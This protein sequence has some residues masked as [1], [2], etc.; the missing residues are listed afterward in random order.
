MWKRRS[1]A[2]G[3]LLLS[4]AEAAGLLG[5]QS[6]SFGA[7]GRT[8]TVTTHSEGTALT[9]DRHWLFQP[10]V[11]TPSAV[12]NNQYIMLFNSNLN[13]GHGGEQ[14][15]AVWM[16][17]SA[18]GLSFA[19]PQQVLT[20]TTVDN[21]CDMVDARPIWGG[22]RWH[23]YFQ[24]MVGDYHQFGT[25]PQAG[26]VA[27]AVTPLDDTDLHHL[28]WVLDAGTN[29]AKIVAST[30]N[31]STAGIGEDMQPF[32]IGPYGGPVCEPAMLTFNDYGNAGHEG[33]LRTYLSRD[34]TVT[35][36]WFQAGSAFRLPDG[37]VTL[38]D[39]ILADALD[40]GTNGNPGLGFESKCVV[41]ASL[42][43]V[44]GVGFYP[45][46]VPWPPRAEPTS[47]GQ[48]Q[49][50]PIESTRSDGTGPVTFRPKPARNE[51]GYLRAVPGSFPRRWETLL[52]Y[53]DGDI[54][55]TPSNCQGEQ[56]Y[57][58]WNNPGQR[59]SVSRLTITEQ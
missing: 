48:W 20:N 27:E 29:H 36:F 14:G 31:P 45:D 49:E 8:Y 52:Y 19:Q 40:F 56:P 5:D 3:L 6:F 28:S 38:L 35:G 24:V 58:N 7:R 16:A 42:Q 47:D 57:P 9:F 11:I 22:R 13:A 50:G 54:K 17:T 26:Y 21:I 46:P 4:V 43:Y 23:V 2:I 44:Y 51:H 30:L 34:G 41:G 37:P 25:C 33:S 18:D 53:N 59:F 39:V 32:N 1:A 15:E 12:T 10:S 55:T